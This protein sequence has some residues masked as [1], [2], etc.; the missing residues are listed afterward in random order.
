MQYGCVVDVF[1]MLGAAVVKSA[2]KLWL[3]DESFAADASSSVVDLVTARISGGLEQRRAQRFFED[4]EVPV[5]KRLQ[6]LRE[7]EFGRLPENEW[8]AAIIA[9]GES[10]DRAHL[11]SKDLFSRDLNPLFLE[12]QI[13]TDRRRA[14][15]DL[16]ADGTALYD[17][18]ISEGC[19]YVVEIAD[20]LPHFQVGAFAELLRRDRQILDFITEVLDRIPAKAVG[21]SDEA[22]FVTAYMRHIATKLDRLELF[23]L[24]FQSPWHPL[25][26]AYVSLRVGEQDSRN[27]STVEERLA[28][29]SRT[30]LI[31]RAGSGKTT[32]LQWLAVRAAR[33]DFTGSLAEL[34]MYIPFFVRLREYVSKALPQPEEYIAGMAPL[35]APEAPPGWAR[36]QLRSGRALMLVDGVDELPSD[37]RPGVAR[38]LH[39]LTELFPA[40]RYV[41]TA[42]PAAISTEW[43]DE[44][45]FTRTFLEVM[46][47]SLIV[48]F[49]QHWHEATSNQVADSEERERLRGYENSLL[50]AIDNDRYLRD[51]AD[52]PLLAG[53]LCSLNWHLR[54]QLPRRRSEIYGR[55]LA[56]LHQR[57]Q[58]R[59]IAT[60]SI[61]LD[62]AAKTHLLADLALWM[63]RNGESEIDSDTAIGRL[64]QSL[65]TLQEAPDNAYPVFRVLLERSGLLREP[66]SGRMDFVHRTFQEYLAAKATID[67]DAIG[68]LVRNADDDQWGEVIVLAVGQANQRQADRLIRGLLGHAQQD[69]PRFIRGL[70][71]RSQQDQPLARRLLAVASMQEVHRL[72]PDLRR[73]VD[74]IIPS[75]IPPESM[76]QAEKLS[77]AGERLLPSLAQ[78]WSRDP[79]KSAE[80]IRAAS[81]V[82][83]HAALDVIVTIIQE[84]Q[85]SGEL[86]AATGNETFRAAQYFDEDDYAD[87]VL[88][89]ANVKS[90]LLN[91]DK[92]LRTAAR[93]PTLRRISLSFQ[94]RAFD[95]RIF[96]RLPQLTEVS[97]LA[98][99]VPSQSFAGLAM[100][101]HLKLLHIFATDA[102]DLTFI[103]YVPTLTR[104]ELE[105]PENDGFSLRGIECQTGLT[106]IILTNFE[107][108]PSL[109][110]LSRLPHLKA[111]RLQDCGV[112]DLT[113]FAG[114]TLAIFTDRNTSLRH[115]DCLGEGSSINPLEQRA[116]ILG[117]AK[118]SCLNRAV[119]VPHRPE[120]S[121]ARA[122]LI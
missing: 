78:Y 87:R 14:T 29:S 97:V 39:D 44:F 70:L 99:G 19:A 111:V 90:L 98:F 88:A 17:R 68:E 33:S 120:F 40:A 122:E 36:A 50:A 13:R 2:V 54:S 3:K 61:E 45:G 75:L 42:R 106:E 107:Q 15:R 28:A 67:S 12:R 114:K 53:L 34:N 92:E 4:L 83:G 48:T 11:T 79:T 63:V 95:L 93:I 109:D 62:L 30:L 24:D 49:V 89:V 115:Q 35:L 102:A 9:A 112:V 21:E 74:E 37:E 101:P 76:E 105:H 110:P 80:T 16:S 72:E 59:K 71:G 117:K 55:A 103:P 47:P 22:R 121:V 60:G 119:S 23:G 26:V 86:P 82:G 25:S 91:S 27:G 8:T 18:V 66:V 96:A 104:F 57:D 64:K 32:V 31:G 38:W 94:N 7:S 118:R 1:L 116:L 100:L 81:L 52:T 41:V 77:I 113:P 85:Q 20:K 65:S 51:L 84:I 56:M 46:S 58:A 69:R 5:A 6:A 10:F 108:L 73:A 43:L